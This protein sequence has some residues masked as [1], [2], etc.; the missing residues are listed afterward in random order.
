MAITEVGVAWNTARAAFAG[1]GVLPSI[2]KKFADCIKCRVTDLLA[3]CDPRYVPSELVQCSLAEAEWELAD[4][5]G[6]GVVASNGLHYFICRM[7]HRSIA[8]RFGRGKFYHLSFLSTDDAE[9]KRTQ[10]ARHADVSDRI[11]PHPHVAENESL[12]LIGDGSGAWV[13]DRWIGQTTLEDRLASG[14][15]PRD[16]LRRIMHEI[17]LGLESLHKAGIVMRELSPARV[18]LAEEDGRAVLADFELAKLLDGK[19][20]VSDQWPD[21]VYRAPEV[22]SGNV[23]ARADL[24]SWARVLVHAATGELPE[25]GA[26]ADG[27]TRVELPKGV[28]RVAVDCLSPD[29]GERPNAMGKIL[30]AVKGWK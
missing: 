30:K 3:P 9:K 28:F 20:T 26:D 29:A 21:D 17:A 19:P 23:D 12:L 27:L 25:C 24:Y 4:Y 6:P 13:V 16:E 2:A 8:A 18:L 15:L 10:V 1:N 11:G 7:R 14:P 22:E 5:L